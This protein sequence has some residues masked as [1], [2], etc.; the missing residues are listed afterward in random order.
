MRRRTML[1]S[2]AALAGTAGCVSTGESPGEQPTSDSVTPSPTDDHTDTRTMTETPT[3]PPDATDV[4]AD[5]DCPSFDDNAD[6]TVCY[7]AAEAAESD[8]LLTAEPQVFDPALRDGDVETLE[9]VLYNRSEWSVSFNPYAWGI[10]RHDDGGGWTHVAPEMHP[11]PMTEV[12]PGLTM[13]WELPSA[14]H[15]SPSDDVQSLSVALDSGVYAFHLTVGYGG[16]STETDAS[17]PEKRVELVA[18]F[19]V[20]EG[21]DPESEESPIPETKSA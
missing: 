15:P 2:I 21:F 4:F 14:P 17:P 6:E 12:A 13:R 10:E 3:S 16:I 11:E 5:F 7:H 1:A 18:L 9:F 8:L 20:D 19:R